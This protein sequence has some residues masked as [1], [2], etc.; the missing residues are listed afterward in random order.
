MSQFPYDRPE[1]GPIMQIRQETCEQ[2][3]VTLW[4]VAIL[5]KGHLNALKYQGKERGC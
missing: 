3:Q 2:N 4:H 5:R 1:R